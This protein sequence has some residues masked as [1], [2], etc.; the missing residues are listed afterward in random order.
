MVGVPP[1]DVERARPERRPLPSLSGPTLFVIPVGQ[2]EAESPSPWVVVQRLVEIS[3]IEVVQVDARKWG[4]IQPALHTIRQSPPDVPRDRFSHPRPP[5][6]VATIQV[7]IAF[8]MKDLVRPPLLDPLADSNDERFS[9]L[10][11]S[12]D[13]DGIYT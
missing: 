6:D 5:E 9:K 8:R 7:G 2:D 13:H 3:S 4:S 12:M 11:G 1:K 10:N